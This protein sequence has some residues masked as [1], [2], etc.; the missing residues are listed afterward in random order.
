M[1]MTVILCLLGFMLSAVPAQSDQIIDNYHVSVMYGNVI[2]GGGSGYNEGS[3]Y[4]YPSGWQ[5]QW[6]YDHPFDDTRGK[7][8]SIQFDWTHLDPTCPVTIE[9]A[10]NWSTPEWSALGHGTEYPPLPDLVGQDEDLY[11]VRVP[12]IDYCGD[13]LP[14]Q[15]V[16]F[17]YVV[18][19]YNPEWVSIDVR[20]C[21]F[22]IING[23]IIHECAVSN[24]TSSWG[25]IKA[26]QR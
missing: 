25:A 17:D 26:L 11:I 18:W 13:P 1:R 14:P 2:G 15:Q 5:T 3:W 20:G 7:I 9:V 10:V 6:F 24:E 8:I 19:D 21:N 16:I 23:I 22:E 4:Q 12:I